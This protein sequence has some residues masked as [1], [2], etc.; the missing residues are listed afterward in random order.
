MPADVSALRAVDSLAA[1]PSPL[2]ELLARQRAAFAAR[3]EPSSLDERRE[4]LQRLEQTLME[5]RLQLADAMSADFG[6]RARQESLL[7]LFVVIDDLRHA[8]ANLKRWM[9]TRKVAATWQF[10]P[11]RAC[12][13]PQPLGVVGVI[14][15]YNY[16]VM[17]TLSPVVGAL[18]AGNHVLMKPSSLTPRTAGLMQEIVASLYPEEEVAVVNGD[19]SVAKRF[20]KLPFDHLM[21]TGSTR[22]GRLVMRDA[23]EHLVPVTLELGG[24][25]PAIVG[26][27]Y[28]LESAAYTIVQA[29]LLNAGQTCVTGDYALVPEA[30]RDA[31]MNHV[32]AAL[33]RYY[34]RLVDNPDYG[35]VLVPADWQRLSDWVDE[36]RSRGAQ[37]ETFNPANEDCNAGNRVFPP[38]IVSRLPDD[39]ALAREEIFGP[40]LPVMTYRTL[41]EA[42]ARVNAGERPLALYFFSKRK[43]DVERV[44]KR[45]IAG[46]VSINGCGYHAIQ[47]RLP[48][49]GVGASGIGAYRG[50]IG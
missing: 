20:S 44:L 10:R 3:G 11:S 24:K 43:T 22:V 23:A 37:V 5:R 12:L 6:G 38:T 46:G 31:F 49:G 4:M 48:F 14:G 7:E 25:C 35:R 1:G 41:D 8:R 40:V 13:M 33:R 17:T 19:S 2:D 9:R 36:A 28:D 16:P 39:T 15:A 50:Q 45:T 30:A 18:A 42:I 27:G 34:P 29:K 26:E 32:R 47:H 21:F